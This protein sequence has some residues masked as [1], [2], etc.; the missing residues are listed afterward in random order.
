MQLQRL[1]GSHSL[2]ESSICS[3]D[4]FSPLDKISDFTDKMM[5][6]YGDA[7]RLTGQ[8]IAYSETCL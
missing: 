7:L 6:R 8:W 3:L 2:P 5:S 4:I 1:Q